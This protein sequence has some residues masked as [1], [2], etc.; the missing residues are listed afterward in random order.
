MLSV[1]FEMFRQL[2]PPVPQRRHW[3]VK[4]IGVDPDHVPGS[5]FRVC[6]STAEPE[7]VGGDVFDGAAALR[8]SAGLVRPTNAAITASPTTS[9]AP[10]SLDMR[11]NFK[12]IDLLESGVAL[13]TFP[14]E[15]EGNRQEADLHGMLPNVL[16]ATYAACS[17]G[18]TWPYRRE[19][20][21]ARS[22]RA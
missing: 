11:W 12:R 17:G 3:Y 14:G 4:S 5:A 22:T 2:L 10:R 8:A 18:P 19:R 7:I 1:A 6:P 16:P 15:A 21:E 20:P 9:V 13:R